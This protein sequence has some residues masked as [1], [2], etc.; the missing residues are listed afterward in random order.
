ML[1]KGSKMGL[2]PKKGEKTKSS[3]K[4]I[5]QIKGA[6]AIKEKAA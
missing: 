3:E 5:K 2:D 6:P 4:V 1:Q